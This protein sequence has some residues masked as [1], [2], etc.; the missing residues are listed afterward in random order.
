MRTMNNK[1]SIFC[2]SCAIGR[3]DF[4]CSSRKYAL[5]IR[6]ASLGDAGAASTGWQECRDLL[7]VEPHP[8]ARFESLLADSIAIFAA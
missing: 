2:Y 7:E 5:S 1:F 6:V 3:S 8:W 4:V